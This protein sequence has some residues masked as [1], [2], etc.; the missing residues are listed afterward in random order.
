[1]G[2]VSFMAHA[3]PQGSARSKTHK[4]H[5]NLQ[6]RLVGV[7]KLER[8]VLSGRNCLVLFSY[9]GEARGRLGSWSCSLVRPD[10]LKPLT[11]RESESIN[12]SLTCSRTRGEQGGNRV[13][14][15]SQEKIHI[16]QAGKIVQLGGHLEGH[17][18]CTLGFNPQH[19]EF[20]SSTHSDP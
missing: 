17:L 20:P 8:L 11:K 3:V 7:K 13:T 19:K 14:G 1:M 10:C 9:N 5:Q 12:L 4:K 15:C 2:K 16:V 6:A 18:P